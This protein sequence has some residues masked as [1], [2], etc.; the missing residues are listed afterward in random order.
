MCERRQTLD[1]QGRYL[2]VNWVSHG[3][4]SVSTY[5]IR[6]V[7]IY[8]FIIHQH[9]LSPRGRHTSCHE[10]KRKERKFPLY[11]LYVVGLATYRFPPFNGCW[12]W[13]VPLLESIHV[14][15]RN[16]N[17]N[18]AS[19]SMPLYTFFILL[20]FSLCWQLFQFF[21]FN[22]QNFI[23]FFIVLYL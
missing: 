7:F 2:T 21:A 6:N 8:L 16:P 15:D 13:F 14:K 22:I 20:L 3:Y 11:A 12:F 5:G 1:I 9:I 23:T 19:S 17:S 18:S 10:K 4:T